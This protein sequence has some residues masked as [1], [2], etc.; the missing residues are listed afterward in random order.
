MVVVAYGLILPQAVLDLPRLGCLNI[1]ASLLPR[2]RGAAPIQRAI[3]AGDAAHRR[4]DHED[5]RRSRHRADAAACARPTSAR[6]RP[7]RAARPAGARSARRRSSRPSQGW[8]A[9][10]IAPVAQPAEGATYAAKIRKEEAQHRLV[11]VLPR[12]STGRCAPSIPGRSRRRAGSATQLR[13]WESAPLARRPAAPG[14]DDEAGCAGAWPRDR[15]ADRAA[16]W[17][18]RA[19]DSLELRPPAAC[20]PQADRGSASSS[21]AHSLAGARLG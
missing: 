10:R 6:A 11:A 2:W 18:Q 17:S 13:I 20:R 5:G 16:S 12:R 14:P 4:H 15:R 9:G 8:A 1:H 3:L 19:M 7:R 21:C